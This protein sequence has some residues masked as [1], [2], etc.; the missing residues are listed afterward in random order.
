MMDISHLFSGTALAQDA[1]PATAAAT[2]SP[3]AQITNF[4]PLILIFVVFYV[5]IIRPQQKKLADQD[6]MVK[7]LKRGDRVITSGGIYGKITRLED[8]AIT[9]EVADNVNIKVVRA[10]VQSLAVKPD[11]TTIANDGDEKKS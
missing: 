10:Q 7:A 4:M 1:A 6:K 8:D 5:L 9:L 3:L 11:T 2:A